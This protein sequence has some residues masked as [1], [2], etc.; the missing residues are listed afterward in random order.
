MPGWP[1]A[2]F[3]RNAGQFGPACKGVLLTLGEG[4]PAC[5]QSR[6]YVAPRGMSRTERL[7]REI[8]GNRLMGVQLVTNIAPNVRDAEASVPPRGRL[9]PG[10]RWPRRRLRVH[11]LAEPSID[12]QPMIAALFVSSDWCAPNESL[13]PSLSSRQVHFAPPRCPWWDPGSPALLPLSGLPVGSAPCRR[14][15][16]RPQNR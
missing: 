4:D 3:A 6:R 10:H 1:N 12:A 2:H 8:A 5:T 16:L 7:Y 13:T 14:H 11:S 15:K 9:R